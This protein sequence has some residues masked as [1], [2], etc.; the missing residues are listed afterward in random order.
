MII[1]RPIILILFFS[2]FSISGC[3]TEPEA[4]APQETE[5]FT[6]PTQIFEGDRDL[7]FEGQVHGEILFLQR[8][9]VE[10][11]RD[12]TF[13][14]RFEA[15]DD[16][17]PIYLG[18]VGQIKW[19]DTT[20][21]MFQG[22][23]RSSVSLAVLENIGALDTGIGSGE[24][25]LAFFAY[26]HVPGHLTLEIDIDRAEKSSR[27]EPVVNGGSGTVGVA[28]SFPAD[29]TRF[30]TSIPVEEGQGLMVFIQ[31]VLAESGGNRTLEAG[32]RFPH[33]WYQRGRAEGCHEV[34]NLQ[35]AFGSP[36]MTPGDFPIKIHERSQGYGEQ[37]IIPV[38]WHSRLTEVFAGLGIDEAIV[39]LDATQT[40]LP[41][42]ILSK[43]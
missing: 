14:A 11:P 15:A 9:S 4:P 24:P 23:A 13:Y 10:L 16:V 5:A 1:M 36:R 19:N 28:E 7:Y 8:L 20:T 17:G 2:A 39:R 3:F 32:E 6:D 26:A 31:E 12:T 25:A 29:G 27:W 41:E 37:T 34:S 43:R 42:R 22:R 30:E 18:D 35:S 40:C 33:Y 38:V 21:Y